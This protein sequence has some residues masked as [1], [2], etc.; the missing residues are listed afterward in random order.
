MAINK[1]TK[2]QLR[3]REFDLL[4]YEKVWELIEK[5]CDEENV[6]D[7][8]LFKLYTEIFIKWIYQFGIFVIPGDKNIAGK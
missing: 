8:Y 2:D 7:Y 5:C 1:I 4:S 6:T 3:K